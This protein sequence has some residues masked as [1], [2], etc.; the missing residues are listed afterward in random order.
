MTAMWETEHLHSAFDASVF[1]G[2]GQDRM[3]AVI[4]QFTD[5]ME[6]NNRLSTALAAYRL[7]KTMHKDPGN[8]LAYS[9]RV[10]EQTHG[11]FS[12]TN[13]ASVFK[14]PIMKGIMQFR[15]QPMNLAIMMYR[16]IGKSLPEKLGGAGDN[17]ARW[18]LAYQLATAAAL[19]G[20]GGMPMDLPKLVGLAGQAAGGPA[21]SDWDDKFYRT[22]E[23]NLGPDAAKL[24]HDGIPG[25]MGPYGP[26]LGHRT[27]FDAGFLFAE[28][29][30]DRPDDLYAYA[31]KS[32][33]GA[34]VGMGFEWL[35]ALHDAE[36]GDYE[37]A[38]EGVLPGTLKD[39]FKAYRLATEGQMAGKAQVTEPGSV[40]DVIQ[41][42]LG[43]SGVE[44][45]QKLAG[46]FALQK[47]MKAQQSV[48]DQLKAKRSHEK[49]VLGVKIPKKQAALGEEYENAYQ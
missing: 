35:Q 27:G 22:L 33:A 13:A 44:R 4:R 19:G 30:S 7:E 47:A 11:V 25:M 14:N 48:S 31:A 17:E 10:I 24:I 12:P 6:A 28:P 49:S 40:G 39:M 8:A 32:L 34:S 45:E 21:P 38:G 23:S 43:F 37:R 15:Q 1:E 29:K 42:L 2:S 16:N 36:Q 3:N 5:A 20:M 9:R 46:H 41:Q 18:T 26:S